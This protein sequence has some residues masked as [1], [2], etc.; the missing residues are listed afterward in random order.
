[1]IDEEEV[2]LEM[3]PLLNFYNIQYKKYKKQS[4]LVFKTRKEL[5]VENN[6]KK[7]INYLKE[8]NNIEKLM[9]IY[10]ECFD[11]KESKKEKILEDFKNKLNEDFLLFSKKLEYLLKMTENTI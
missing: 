2:A 5:E 11:K 1:L 7:S 3:I 9:Y 8:E 6:L 10:Y 4:K